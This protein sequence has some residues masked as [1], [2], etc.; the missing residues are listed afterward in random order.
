MHGFEC[1]PWGI[2][3][4]EYT[5]QNNEL[6]EA[7]SSF[8]KLIKEY[9]QEETI[10]NLSQ[11]K[12]EDSKL[13][14]IIFTSLARRISSHLLKQP[15]IDI[16]NIEDYMLSTDIN[17]SNKRYKYRNDKKIPIIIIYLVKGK[18]FVFPLYYITIPLIVGGQKVRY[19]IR[20][21]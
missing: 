6:T 15:L 20:N 9:Y 12:N 10:N 4:N 16:Y 7:L 14:C 18:D 2:F 1:L 19:V 3:T 11:I 8:T 5:K 21:N 17:Q 13:F